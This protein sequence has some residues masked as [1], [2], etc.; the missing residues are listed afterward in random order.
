MESREA[1]QSGVTGGC[2]VLPWVMMF[3]AV[4]ASASAAAASAA[5]AAAAAAAACC[6]GHTFV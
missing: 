6:F 3:V 1:N 2:G 4:A 5:V